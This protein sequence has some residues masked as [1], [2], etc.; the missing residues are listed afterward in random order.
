MNDA[1]PL[2]YGQLSVWRDVRGLRRDRR[3]EANTQAIW[4]I[5]DCAGHTAE[6]V[7]AAVLTLPDRH[8]SL[9]TA[10]DLTDPYA[11]T[12]HVLPALEHVDG[13][14]TECAPEEFDALVAALAAEPFDLGTAP[15]WRFRVVTRDGAPRAV[16]LIQHHITA[17][18]WSNG[19]LEADFREALATPGHRPADAAVT[20]RRLALWQREPARRARHEALTAYWERV[21]T[22]DAATLHTPA[23]AGPPE[24][25]V[26]FSA[27]SRAAYAGAR[28][29]AEALSIPVSSLVLAAFA[30]SVAE[31]AGEGTVIAQLMS[32][33]RF[34]PPWNTLVSSMN[35]WTAAAL[36]EGALAAP[37][38][39]FP[40]FAAHVHTRGLLA[41]RHGMYDVDEMDALRDKL[42]GGRTPYEATCA[43]N[44]L[45]GAAPPPGT[46]PE[47]G[48]DP[49]VPFSRIGHPCYLR[50]TDEGG[51]TLHLRLRTMG[52]TDTA[53]RDVLLGTLARL[54]GNRS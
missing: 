12:Q 45:T 1:A 27:R 18:G 6:Q 24:S 38:T 54:D 2:T 50:A 28:R 3:H 25:A 37:S 7:A 17:D 34:V 19:R 44:F 47:S 5:P 8:E 48:P 39:P 35:Q 23:N 20:P 40:S 26:Q 4:P 11:P 42:R 30:R 16:V 43:F 32:S 36:N 10:Y 53:T 52:L 49:E 41:Y 29:Q 21:F 51:D 31:A 13:S 14:I 22:A 9:R 33:N 46:G 15:T